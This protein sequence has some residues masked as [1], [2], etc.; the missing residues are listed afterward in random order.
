MMLLGAVTLS[1]ALGRG[2]LCTELGTTPWVEF[3]RQGYY[4]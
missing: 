3:N 4:L 2:T 1:D